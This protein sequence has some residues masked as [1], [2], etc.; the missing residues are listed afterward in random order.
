[1]GVGVDHRILA[2]TSEP[3]LQLDSPNYFE[4]TNR[5]ALRRLYW[6]SKTCS[7]MSTQRRVHTMARHLMLSVGRATPVL[8]MG[9]KCVE[10]VRWLRPS[11]LSNKVGGVALRLMKDVIPGGQPAAV[12][13]ERVSDDAKSRVRL[14]FSSR[15]HRAVHVSRSAN[16]YFKRI[17]FLHVRG[18]CIGCSKH[19]LMQ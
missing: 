7:G 10:L 2:T 9:V 5:A 4:C 1:M 18:S 17:I 15:S 16:A 13:M 8:A 11:S 12:A 6:G 19:A 14:R 3:I